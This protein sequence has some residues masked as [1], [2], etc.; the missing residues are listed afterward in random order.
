MSDRQRSNPERFSPDGGRQRIFLFRSRC[1][2]ELFT[3]QIRNIGSSEKNRVHIVPGLILWYDVCTFFSSYNEINPVKSN[4]TQD[5]IP[6]VKQP[7]ADP[8]RRA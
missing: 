1:S 6:P 4:L 3:A 8:D 5:G 2:Q 7:A